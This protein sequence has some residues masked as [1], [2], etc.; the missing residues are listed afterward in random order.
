LER[1]G[2]LFDPFFNVHS[3]R[4]VRAPAGEAAPEH[5]SPTIDNAI[6][7]IRQT[8]KLS[9]EQTNDQTQQA[10]PIQQLTTTAYNSA[11]KETQKFS[12]VGPAQRI[13]PAMLKP[14]LKKP[15]S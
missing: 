5:G 10:E 8:P 14:A 13:A 11:P 7:I 2:P 3:G 1:L 4:R 6:T 9:H 15:S 12:P